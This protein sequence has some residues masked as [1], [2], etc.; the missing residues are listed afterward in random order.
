MTRRHMLSTRSNAE[1]ASTVSNP[2]FIEIMLRF[3]DTPFCPFETASWSRRKRNRSVP[4]ER[5]PS[6]T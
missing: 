5:Q 6:Q 3:K 1:D 4:L 2:D